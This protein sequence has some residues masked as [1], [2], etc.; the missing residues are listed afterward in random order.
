MAVR[1]HAD[2]HDRQL[3]HLE[4][5]FAAAGM[6]TFGSG[7]TKKN[8]RLTLLDEEYQITEM[9]PAYIAVAK[10]QQES[11][12]QRSFEWAMAAGFRHKQLFQKALDAADS[13]RDLVLGP[14]QVCGICGYTIEGD[15]PD[16]CPLCKALMDKFV[17][18]E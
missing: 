6:G 16:S 17:A 7:I 4:G 15:A 3:R 8:L 2:D 10:L 14:V 9:Y 13:S 12:P 11:D 18:F 5:E 1:I